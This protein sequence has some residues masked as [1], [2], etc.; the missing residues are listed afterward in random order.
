MK[1]VY[2]SMFGTQPAPSVSPF[3]FT[4]VAKDAVS[5]N[6][7]VCVSYV[8]NIMFQVTAISMYDIILL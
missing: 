5:I 1:R 7:D 2:L 3:K 4:L 8:H 6:N